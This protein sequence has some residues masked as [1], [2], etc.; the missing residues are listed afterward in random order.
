M[1]LLWSLPCRRYF[2]RHTR[3]L[4]KAFTQVF[5]AIVTGSVV[6]AI[7]LSLLGVG[8]NYFC[9]GTGKN[10]YGSLPNLFSWN[11]CTYSNRA[12]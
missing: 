2:R 6:I 10:D 5:P 12:S 11:G 9:G 7:G 1:E 8:I 4:L 3:S